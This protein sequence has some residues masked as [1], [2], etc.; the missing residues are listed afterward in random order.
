MCL[1]LKQK[2]IIEHTAVITTKHNTN[3][4]SSSLDWLLGYVQLT[5]CFLKVYNS[6]TQSISNGGLPARLLFTVAA[7]TRNTVAAAVVA[8]ASN[9]I[10]RTVAAGPPPTY[11]ASV[12]VK[13]L[14]PNAN[15]RANTFCEISLHAHTVAADTPWRRLRQRRARLHKDQS[16]IRFKLMLII[17]RV[18]SC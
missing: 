8:A 14:F 6:T 11:K 1:C 7:N 13:L 2:S 12:R 10:E 16:G 4:L 15:S 18:R 17:R 3:K 5:L 9:N